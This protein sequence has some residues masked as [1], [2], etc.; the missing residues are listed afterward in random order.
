[1]S[2]LITERQLVVFLT[3]ELCCDMVWV[4]T[5]VDPVEPRLEI[6]RRVLGCLALAGAIVPGMTMDEENPL[7]PRREEGHVL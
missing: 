1:M 2:L 5:Q 6:R 3:G 7:F 4:L